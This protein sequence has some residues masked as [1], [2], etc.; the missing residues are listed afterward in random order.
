[1]A[2][3]KSVKFQKNLDIDICIQR[4]TNE[5]RIQQ[6]I[7]SRWQFP[8]NKHGGVIKMTETVSVHFLHNWYVILKDKYSEVKR[9]T[10]WQNLHA[11]EREFGIH[12]HLCELRDFRWVLAQNIFNNSK[13]S[14]F[15]VQRC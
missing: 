13:K 5:E 4:S 11:K 1:M 8:N 15:I 2:F 7:I 14:D 9:T 6:K 10:L 3:D 12:V